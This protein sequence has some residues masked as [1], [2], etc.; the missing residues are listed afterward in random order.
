MV[1]KLLVHRP[2]QVFMREAFCDRSSLVERRTDFF[3]GIRAD[4][5]ELALLY[6]VGAVLVLVPECRQRNLELIWHGI[7]AANLLSNL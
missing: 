1:E 6:Q 4:D 7:N 5:R 3:I 2:T